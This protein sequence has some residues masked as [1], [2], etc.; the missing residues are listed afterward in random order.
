MVDSAGR[1]PSFDLDGTLIDSAADIRTG[2]NA[3][4]KVNGLRELTLAETIS[5]IGQGPQR[6]IERAFA[7]RG[8]G[9]VQQELQELTQ[10]F[11]AAYEQNPA[12]ETRAFPGAREVIA[13]LRHA[14]RIGIC[15]NKP[16]RLAR[17]ALARCGLA[18]LLDGLVGSDSGFGRKPDAGPVRALL[19][20]LDVSSTE[21]LYVGDSDIDVTA[22][23]AA[24]V[25]VAVVSFG[26]AG[27]PA[28]QLG[29]DAILGTFADLPRVIKELS[30][31]PGEVATR[32]LV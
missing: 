14:A 11:V 1:E 6:L 27:R 28:E 8:R 7:F 3:I 2:L 16:V 19:D 15:T 26:Y 25:K 4:L 9:L 24:G 17:Q 12:P 22:A 29:A 5:L 30:L 18:T 31:R 10:R 21:A 32:P 20:S 13:D 23:R